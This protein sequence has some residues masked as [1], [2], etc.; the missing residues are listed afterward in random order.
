MWVWQTRIEIRQIPYDAKKGANLTFARDQR[1]QAVVMNTSLSF[2]KTY[3]DDTFSNST[4]LTP[5]TDQRAD[6]STFCQE[7]TDWSAH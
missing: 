6:I 3:D 4:V 5:K 7:L 2:K 1:G